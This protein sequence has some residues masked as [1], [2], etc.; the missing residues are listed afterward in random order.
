MNRKLFINTLDHYLPWPVQLFS[1]I[2]RVGTQNQSMDL[3][4]LPIAGDREIRES[5]LVEI[6]NKEVSWCRGDLYSMSYPFNEDRKLSNGPD[7]MMSGTG[8]SKQNSKS[9]LT[10]SIQCSEQEREEEG[11]NSFLMYREV[12]GGWSASRILGQKQ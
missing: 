8:I 4:G 9:L 2:L 10:S 3:E 12:N 7:V 1:E 11:G 6:T 5:V